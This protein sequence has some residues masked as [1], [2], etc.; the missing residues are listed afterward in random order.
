MSKKTPE[1][2]QADDQ[3]KVEEERKRKALTDYE[4]HLEAVMSLKAMT[5]TP[6][7]QEHYRHMR[8]RIEAHGQE[9]LNAEK[10]REVVQHQEGAKI[11]RALIERVKGPVGDLNHY[12]NA[13]PLFVSSMPIRAEWNGALGTVELREISR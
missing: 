1:E 4:K 8:A 3:K 13:M 9:V 6:A 7:W 12:I 11:L 2:K 10:T 5:D